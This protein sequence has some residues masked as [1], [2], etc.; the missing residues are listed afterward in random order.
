MSDIFQ[1]FKLNST[2]HE[3]TRIFTNYHG[4]TSIS[5]ID[6][7][8]TNIPSNMYQAKVVNAF[9]AD[10]YAQVIDISIERKSNLTETN[11]ESTYRNMSAE[12]INCLLQ[13]IKKIDFSSLYNITDVNMSI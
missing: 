7:L 13:N 2:T 9:I 3:P 11:N 10:H 6:Y 4:Q 5:I 12:N 1:S 8:T